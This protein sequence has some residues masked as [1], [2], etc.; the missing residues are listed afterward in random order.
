MKRSLQLSFLLIFLCAFPLGIVAQSY[1]VTLR[2]VEN[3]TG[4]ALLAQHGLKSST[5][6]AS[7]SA[8][9][10]FIQSIVPSLQERGFLAA[11]VDSIAIKDQSYD[12][13]L[14]IGKQYKWAQ[15]SFDS[16][17]QGIITLSGIKKEQW[18]GR[19]LNVKQV[20][21]V[22]E[23]LLQWAENNGYPFARVW[24]EGISFEENGTVMGNFMFHRGPEQVLDT[25]V[26]NGDVKVSRNYLLNYLDLEQGE[27]YNEKKLRNISPRLRELPFLQEAA[28]WTFSFKLSE[29]ILN[30]YLKEKKAN[31][32]NAI[33]GLL[34]NSTE[35]GKFLLTVDAQFAFQNILAQGESISLSYQNLQ[36]KSPRLK[37]DLI[38]PYL[39]NTP[40]GVDVHFDLFKKDTTFR[41]TSLQAGIRYQLSPTDYLR[42]FY[43]NQSNRLITIDTNFVRRNKRLPDNID[44]S[45]NGAGIEIG[46]NRTDYRISPRKGWEARLS[47]SALVRRVKQS[48]AITGLVDVS[49][50]DYST[51]YDTLV[52]RQ[53]Q[54]FI[55]GTLAYYVPLGKKA[56]FKSAYNGGWVGGASLFRNELYQIG[57]FRLL[58]GFDEQSIFTSN[59]HVVT[60]ELRLLLDQNSFF[61]LFSDNGY[62]ESDFNGFYKDD[63][64]NGF[65]L[66]TTL[67]TKSGLFSIS[68]A[69]GRN[70]AN[71]IQF[72]QS[73]I[74][75]GYLA[76]F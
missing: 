31:L 74:H 49:G 36:Y 52:K 46:L 61:Y 13:F 3:T 56:V 4:E 8:A 58:R 10:S 67:E 73:K 65:G 14:F 75:F 60:L 1:T 29:N 23:R 43:Q 62:V 47:S 59:Y 44:V 2:S 19:A 17:P 32:L 71:P 50:F 27:L 9:Y 37:A 39:F 16:I 20:S 42:V 54:Y 21:K 72:R 69:L 35:T 33:V 68:Y 34:P 26:L 51:L 24:L 30:L 15:V 28:P 64:Y 22:S 41:R 45:A 25:I 76:Y 11:S 70:S 63:I 18:E 48:D 5:Q 66:G 55:N 57:G 38:Y 7:A 6:F 40:F 53:Y 12:A